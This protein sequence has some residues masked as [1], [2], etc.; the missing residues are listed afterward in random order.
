[1]RWVWSGGGLTW[2]VLATRIWYA[3]D[4]DDVLGRSAQ[5]SFYFLLALF[6]LLIFLSALLGQMFAEDRGLY[7]RLLGY[8]ASVMPRS[9]YQLMRGTVDEITAGTSGQKLSIGFVVALWTASSGME[10]VIDGLNVAYE[11]KERRPWWRRRI[12]AIGL[13]AMLAITTVLALGLLLAGESIGRFLVNRF[14]LE[15]GFERFW[16]L[17]QLGI[18][19]A[20]ML[21]A[22]AFIYRFA[23]N[24]KDYGWQGMMPGAICAVVLWVA[25]TGMFRLYLAFFDNYNKT[26]GSLGAVIVLLL[27]LYMSGVAILVGGEVNSEIRQAAAAAGV[28]VAQEPIEA[29]APPC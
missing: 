15:E 6:P 27:W 4:R 22:F 3:I 7:G 26:Y 18:P 28:K 1:M 29:P 23:P 13:T 16:A 11:V 21:L 24:I 10:A 9:A 8:L 5:L 20:F 12:L 14:Q 19:I 25:V 2:R 17:A